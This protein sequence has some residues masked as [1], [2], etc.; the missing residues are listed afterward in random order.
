M[1]RTGRFSRRAVPATNGCTV[2]VALVEP[3]R[4]TPLQ[5]EDTRMGI[6]RTAEQ[7]G[8]FMSDAS[9]EKQ[10]QILANQA[11]LDEILANQ[12]TIKS[13][14]SKLDEILANQEKILGKLG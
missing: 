13:N 2:Q 9:S 7:Q 4:T 3:E 12:V 10:D 8:S 14:Q 11:K 6:Q 1:S 5:T